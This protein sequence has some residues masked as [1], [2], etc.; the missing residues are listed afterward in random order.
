MLVIIAPETLPST[1]HAIFTILERRDL[2]H[3]ERRGFI[4][5]NTTGKW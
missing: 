5:D 1:L 4:Q 3:G 2:R